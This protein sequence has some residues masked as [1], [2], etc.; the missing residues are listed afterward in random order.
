MTGHLG[1]EQEPEFMLEFRLKA[2]RKWL[3]LEEPQWANVNH[4]PIDYQNICYYSAPK[5]KPVKNSLDEVDP[6]I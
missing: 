4:P 2:Y 6:E 1:K 5:K 3:T